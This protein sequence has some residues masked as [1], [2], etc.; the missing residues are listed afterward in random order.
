MHAGQVAREEGLRLHANGGIVRA[1]AHAVGLGEFG[2]QI[3]DHGFGAR[4]RLLLAV[5]IGHLH[6]VDV[7]VGAIGGAVAAADAPVL[8]HDIQRVLAA[9]GAHRAARH[10]QRVHAG[11]ATGGHQEILEAQAVA[12]QAGDAVVVRGHAGLD[13]FVAARA[14]VE[15]QQQQV[16]ALHQLLFEEGGERGLLHAAEEL[17]IHLAARARHFGDAAG[18]FGKSLHHLG[19]ILGFDAHQLDEVHRGAGGGAAAGL[20]RVFDHFE[21]GLADHEAF[22][23]GD[24]RGVHR[25]HAE[26]NGIFAGAEAGDAQLLALHPHGGVLARDV[27]VPG[28]GQRAGRAG[29]RVPR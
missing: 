17:Q 16:L 18:D 2:A 1:G 14:L 12:H 11:A 27:L 23:R 19:E 25:P 28:H 21:G 29:R 20:Q 4:L 8:D 13:A 26:G 22:A 5:R 6:H 10:A 7:A 3:A 9:D 24:Q 15:I